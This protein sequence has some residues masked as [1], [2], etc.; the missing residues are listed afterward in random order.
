MKEFETSLEAEFDML[1]AFLNTEIPK[2]FNFANV[3]EEDFAVNPHIDDDPVAS[4]LMTYDMFNSEIPRAIQKCLKGLQH[5]WL[6]IGSFKISD[7][8]S[9]DGVI[10]KSPAFKVTKNQIDGSLD[11]NELRSVWMDRLAGSSR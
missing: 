5:D 10:T 2:L 4:F 1:Y 6:V 11:I 3:A 8:I 9:A 7:P